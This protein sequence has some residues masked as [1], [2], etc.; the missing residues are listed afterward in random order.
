MENE[1]RIAQL[2]GTVMIAIFAV[3]L[4]AVRTF[5]SL[6][7]GWREALSYV[8]LYLGVAVVIRMM[9]LNEMLSQVDARVLNGLVATIFVA[10]EITS[11]MEL[12]L[13]R[14]AER[15]VAGHQ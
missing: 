12:T 3:L 10:A 9:T 2:I 11:L 8:S 4:F 5:K 7:D 15:R 13:R 14:R 6:A 1:H